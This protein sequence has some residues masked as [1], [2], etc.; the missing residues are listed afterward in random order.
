MLPIC[1][2]LLCWDLRPIYYWFLMSAHQ[3]HQI[4]IQTTI[5][6]PWL[7][8]SVLSVLLLVF[9][10]GL[11]KLLR[12]SPFGSALRGSWTPT[13]FRD[14]KEIDP[15]SLSLTNEPIVLFYHHTS[16]WTI[17]VGISRFVPSYAAS[18]PRGGVSK[19]EGILVST[20]NGF[21]EYL[22]LALLTHPQ[23]RRW[24]HAAEVALARSHKDPKKFGP[25]R[26]VGK[27][28]RRNKNVRENFD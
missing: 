22:Q 24:I 25:P 14:P 16:L 8:P 7:F 3:F 5:S 20:H 27:K 21:G 1:I 23:A 2:L 12:L 13:C 4:Q 9:L 17:F 10:S 26:V 15:A 28:N 19:L 11:T 6:F 18:N